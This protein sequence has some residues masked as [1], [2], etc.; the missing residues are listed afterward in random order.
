MS[1]AQLC[2][3]FNPTSIQS[4][5][6]DGKLINDPIHGHIRLNRICLDIVDTPEFQRLRDLK[7]LGTTYFIFPGAS[8]CRFEHSIGV[9]HLAGALVERLGGLQ[10]E[11][12][13][14]RQDLDMVRV[15]GL[16][17]DLGHGPF[18]HVFDNEV[19]PYLVP[20]S[21]WRHEDASTMM[22]EYLLNENGLD[23]DSNDVSFVQDLIKGRRPTNPGEKGFLFD[24][25]ANSRNSVD[26][27]KFD[28]LARDSYNLGLKTS[29]DFS[30]LMNF[31]K[32]IQ[33]EICFHAKEVYTVYE[34]FHTRYSL[35]RQVYSHRVGKAIEYMIRDAM[36]AANPVMQFDQ[37][38]DDPSLY[39][40]LTDC[41]VRNIEFSKD[42]RLAD[43]Q[44]ILKRIRRRNL[45]KCADEVVLNET[46]GR[47]MKDITGEDV[48]RFQPQGGD[49]RPDEVIVNSF[50]L[51]Y[52]MKEKNPVDKIHFFNKWDKD[53][54]FTIP[55]EK[56]SPLAPHVFQ[57]RHLRIFV[58]DGTKVDLARDAFR[59]L[60][61]HNK[62]VSPIPP[63][64]PV[65]FY[66]TDEPMTPL[67]VPVANKRAREE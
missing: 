27:D 60:L 33:D 35:F 12:D 1:Q 48:V 64:A 28:Y 43:A 42:P 32:V 50:A 13:I 62:C 15:A 26:V 16:C 38:I 23:W 2:A 7:Q 18:S 10:P 49:L 6:E 45:Y 3:R 22:F 37:A 24:V 66:D 58:R 41:V 11:L 5:S 47:L 14:T 67:S 29:Y 9:C 54:Y 56:V 61:R 55:R 52:S 25:V 20:G 19:I 46:E 51:D 36:I 59:A 63:R 17:H 44:A 53:E 30:R 34:M 4:Y 8:H 21:T 31:S 65:T 57:E 39:R 40:T